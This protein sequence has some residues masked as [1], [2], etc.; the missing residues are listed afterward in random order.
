MPAQS[1]NLPITNES[2][3]SQIKTLS[4]FN[5]YFEKTLQLNAA[6][7]D[8]ILG[9]FNARMG[10]LEAAEAMT[11]AVIT[12]AFENNI[13]PL[14]LIKEMRDLDGIELTDTL[15]LFLNETRRNTSLLGTVTPRQVN[16]NV[17][18]NIIA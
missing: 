11:S 18:R 6:M 9:F 2:L 5:G 4:F 7:Y 8:A 15:A 14:E 1:T 10:S 16:R 3:D 17:S 12:S 13:D